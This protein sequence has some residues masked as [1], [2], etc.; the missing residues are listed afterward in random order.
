MFLFVSKMKNLNTLHLETVF[1]TFSQNEL[2]VLDERRLRRLLT[3]H[4]FSVERCKK[5]LD[6]Y[7]SLRTSMPEFFRNRDPLSKK[8]EQAMD[9]VWVICFVCWNHIN[10]TGK[11]KTFYALLNCWIML[12]RFYHHCLISVS[13]CVVPNLMKCIDSITLYMSE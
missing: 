8:L 6:A 2:T 4:K 1:Y 7:Y 11:L 3:C 5:T 12:P 13:E 10:G 9:V